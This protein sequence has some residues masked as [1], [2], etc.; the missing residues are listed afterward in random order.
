ME[1]AVKDWIQKYNWSNQI[2]NVPGNIATTQLQLLR[3]KIIMIFATNKHAVNGNTQAVG[4]HP[5]ANYA[6]GNNPIAG[7]QCCGIYSNDQKDMDKVLSNAKLG[8]TQHESHNRDHLHF[9]YWQVTVPFENIREKTIATTAPTGPHAKL[10]EYLKR[11]AAFAQPQGQLAAKPPKVFTRPPPQGPAVLAPQN[12]N[13]ATA[14]KY[15]YP[16]VISHD[17]VDWHTCQQIISLNPG[18][19]W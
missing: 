9:V 16:N 15:P 17:F 10:E 19:T 11:T 14:G 12:F 18:Y 6:P 3:G 5:Y 13:P 2:Y 8:E 7:I 1:Q 4:L